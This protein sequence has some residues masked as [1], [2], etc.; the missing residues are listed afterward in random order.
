MRNAG[1]EYFFDHTF[2][3]GDLLSQNLVAKADYQYRTVDGKQQLTALLNF[4]DDEGRALG[5]RNLRYQIVLKNKVVWNQSIKT[6]ALGSVS[7]KID[8]ADKTNL[9]GAYIRAT[10]DGSN[11]YPIVRDFAIKAGRLQT[12]VQFFPEGGNLVNGIT[13]KVGFK[14]VGVDGLGISIKGKI[15]D[16][17]AAEVASFETLHAGMGNFV[18]KPQAGKSYSTSISLPNGNILTLP[19]P[20]AVDDGYTLN[21]YQPG[22]DSVLVRIH[23]SAN[24]LN[25]PQS[26]GLIAQTGGENIFASS[27]KIE[28][29]MTSVWI[30]KKNFP[31]GV[32]QFTLFNSN[33]E[34]LSERVAF[35]RGKDLMALD[36]KTAKD[37]YKSKEHVKIDLLAMDSK[38]K[39]TAGNF[40]VTVV[41]EGKMPIEESRES[42]IFSHLLLT[43]DLKGYV[44]RP[45]YYFTKETEEVNRALDNL[46][47]TQGY[48]RFAWKQLESFTK[49]K[50]R[51]EVEGLGAKI[52]GRVTTLSNKPLPKATVTLMSVIAG[53]TKFTETDSVGRFKFDGIFMTDSIKFSV[54]ARGAKNT[55]KVKILV[56]QLP[57]L[58]VLANPNLSD[59]TT[60]IAATLKEYIDNGKKLDDIY[61]QT[62]QLDKVHRLREVRIKARKPVPPPYSNQGMFKIPEGLSDQTII[63]APDDTIQTSLGFWLA[64]KINFSM[65]K[66]WGALR[67]IP[68]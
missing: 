13:S 66:P 27:V 32:A 9:N 3:V 56:D 8:N 64:H 15:I 24:L 44:E 35:I 39:P 58:Q 59:V 57:N 25:Q 21:V 43:S 47:L 28:K 52:T 33:G 5:D 7:I 6:D 55:D 18:L 31:S 36:L 61:E 2:T 60:N 34:P 40:S 10:I 67:L 49:A 42:T 22:K 11:K 41:D 38:G 16:E 26:V 37:T 45:N 46:M 62:G 14:A 12:D 65:L 20:K 30:D 1:P 29:A 68:G 4:T 54:Q 17:L 63:I 48:R 53:V 19:L 50:P 51:F 23:A